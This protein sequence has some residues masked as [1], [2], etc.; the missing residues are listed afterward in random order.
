[1]AVA[2]AALLP[3]L[4]VAHHPLPALSGTALLAALY[5]GLVCTGLAYLLRAQV[6]SLRAVFDLALVH[7]GTGAVALEPLN[8]GHRQGKVAAKAGAD[9]HH[10]G[11]GI[12]TA[13]GIDLAQAT[14]TQTHDH[15]AKP[16]HDRTAKAVHHPTQH[17]TDDR[18][19]DRL[20]SRRRRQGGFAPAP[21]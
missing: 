5:L 3:L 7:W 4:L 20:Q 17:G 11:T 19:L 16:N 12:K 1:M 18:R 15:H 14:Q 9:G 10:H 2:V 21:P 6:E 13:Q 8:Q